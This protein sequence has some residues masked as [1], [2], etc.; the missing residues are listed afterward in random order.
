MDKR[1]LTDEE[2][3]HIVA[4]QALGKHDR[5]FLSHYDMDDGVES[6]RAISK[7]QR[8]R[9]VEWLYEK[10]DCPINDKFPSQNKIKT[11]RIDCWRC[12]TKLKE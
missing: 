8:I 6:G 12:R 1:D 9:V 7:A 5:H 3:K 10:C 2:I 4:I 11:K